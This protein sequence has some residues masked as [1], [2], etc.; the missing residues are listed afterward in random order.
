MLAAEA[1]V[2]IMTVEPNGTDLV[3]HQQPFILRDVRRTE[4]TNQTKGGGW[5]EGNIR[6]SNREII[7]L[8]DFKFDKK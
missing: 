1:E 4:K 5:E 3:S 2:K 8:G 6:R 7:N